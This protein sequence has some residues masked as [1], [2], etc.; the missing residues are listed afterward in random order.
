MQILAQMPITPGPALIVFNKMDQVD[1]ER[2][3]AAKEEFPQ[4][5]F[6]SAHDNLGL[7]TLRQ[8]LCQLVKYAI[9]A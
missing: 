9:A 6:I 1:G 8:R 4:A 2:F 5:L 7:E 3:V